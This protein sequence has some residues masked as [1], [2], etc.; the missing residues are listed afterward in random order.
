MLVIQTSQKKNQIHIPLE[1]VTRDRPTVV[2]LAA[3]VLTTI[4][5]ALLLPLAESVERMLL[6][7]NLTVDFKHGF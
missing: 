6:M 7:R 5:V 4:S 2:V 3:G 1:K